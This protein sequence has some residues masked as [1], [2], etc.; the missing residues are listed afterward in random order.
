M[1]LVY[2]QAGQFSA[3]PAEKLQRQLLTLVEK[4]IG[5]LARSHFNPWGRKWLEAYF[6][7]A[8]LFCYPLI[9]A[10]VLALYFTGMRFQL[11]QSLVAIITLQMRYW[12]RPSRALFLL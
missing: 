1:L 9:P 11:E 12:G 6:E 5:T 10:G 8:Y 2:W 3:K 4:L 7:F